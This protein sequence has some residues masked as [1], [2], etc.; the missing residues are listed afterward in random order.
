MSDKQIRHGTSSGYGRN[1]CRC[2]K[3]RTWR[4]GV[5]AAYRQRRAIGATVN[6]GKGACVPVAM[7]DG[8]VAPSVTDAARA[9][10]VSTQ[11]IRKYLRRD[12]DL[13][14]LA[15][16][17]QIAATPAPRAVAPGADT[18]GTVVRLSREILLDRAGIGLPVGVERPETAPGGSSYMVGERVSNAQARIAAVI[19][20]IRE[21]R[22]EYLRGPA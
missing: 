10:G 3:C 15:P 8:T 16:V 9:F 21:C 13:R 18:S 5:N 6:D 7:P 2:G 20:T 14:R 4:A 1:G 22:D 17:R 12:G 11:T 19:A